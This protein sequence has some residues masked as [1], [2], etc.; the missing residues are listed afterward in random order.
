MHTVKNRFH[1]MQAA[2]SRLSLRRWDVFPSFPVNR[3]PKPGG[4]DHQDVSQ[5]PMTSMERWHLYSQGLF[6]GPQNEIT[7][8]CP[9][10][11]D[12]LEHGMT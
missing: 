7:E 10:S 8:G 3:R 6:T 12:R 11:D 9:D 4:N 2:A 1:P 5:Q